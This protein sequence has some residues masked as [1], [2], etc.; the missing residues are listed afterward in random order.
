MAFGSET[1]KHL[2]WVANHSPQ[3]TP[4]RARLATFAGIDAMIDCTHKILYSDAEIIVAD[5]PSGLLS[6]PGIGPQNQDCLI[7]RVQQ[8]FL[9][10]RIVH[11]LDQHTSG[12]IVLALDAD[13]HRNLGRQFEERRV[14]KRYIALVHG[15]VADDTGE[16]NLPLRKDM[17]RKTRHIVD[18]EQGKH[19]VTF[20]TV[21][22]RSDNTTRIALMPKT[23]RS[24]QL[25]VHMNELGHP[26]LG[27]ELYAPPEVVALA[28]RLM[29]HAEMLTITHPRTGEMMTFES[30]CPF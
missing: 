7:A 26:I 1:E 11:R 4:E 9:Q 18:H 10:A 23:G 17:T 2:Q 22:N 5:K 3:Q 30:L 24:H 21:I 19:A 8:Q 12:V 29:L 13:A 27:D 15:N 28:P 25:R 14:A 6:V 16:I 20:W